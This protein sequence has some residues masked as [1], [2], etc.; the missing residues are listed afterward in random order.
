MH[1]TGLDPVRRTLPFMDDKRWE[2]HFQNL[3][4]QGREFRPHSDPLVERMARDLPPGRALDLACG[5]GGNALWLAARG[6]KVTAVDRSPAAIELVRAQAEQR[7]IRID[8]RIADL[9]AHEFRIEPGAWDLILLCR[10]LQRDLFEP[11]RLGLAPGGVLIVIALLAEP[12]SSGAFR[13]QP[14]ELAEAFGPSSGW[15]VLHQREIVHLPEGSSRGHA[16]AEMVIR[17]DR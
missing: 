13:V 8:A 6:W 5:A 10:Y 3:A 7:G 16:L 2:A 12:G 9:E 1:A 11:A 4:A 17:R 14:G 15:S